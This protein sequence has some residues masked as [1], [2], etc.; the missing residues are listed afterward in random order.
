M[1]KKC[2]LSIW[3]FFISLFIDNHHL[4]VIE[5][6]IDWLIELFINDNVTVAQMKN[7]EK[8]EMYNKNLKFSIFFLKQKII[9]VW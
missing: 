5:K 2:V 9:I 6:M 1:N 7:K 8:L 3:S 4:S